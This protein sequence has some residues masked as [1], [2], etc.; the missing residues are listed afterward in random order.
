MLAQPSEFLDEPHN[1]RPF[2]NKAKPPAALAKAAIPRNPSKAVSWPPSQG[3]LSSHAILAIYSPLRGHVRLA[4]S[5]ISPCRRQEGGPECRPLREERYIDE[6]SS[7]S[8]TERV[9]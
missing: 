1:D 6:D 7:S 8:T 3:L 4:E 9:F 5:I 2:L